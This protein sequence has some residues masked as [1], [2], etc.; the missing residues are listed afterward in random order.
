MKEPEYKVRPSSRADPKD[1]FRIFLSPSQLLLHNL[2]AGDVCHIVTLHQSSTRPAVVWPALE[3]IKDDVVQTSKALQVLYGLK[4]DSRISIRRGD[5]AI[6]DADEINICEVPQ[7][8]SE[9][10][11]PNVQKNERSHWAWILEYPLCNA[12]LLAP[13][14]TFDRVEAKGQ[15]R[16]FQIQSINSSTYPALYRARPSCRVHLNDGN[17]NSATANSFEDGKSLIVPSEGIG[18]LGEQLKQLNDVF[19]MYSLS[20]K[21]MSNLPLF[22]QKQG[23]ILLHGICGTGK[24][25]LLSNICKA[26]WRKVFHIDTIVYSQRSGEV[27]T[28]IRQTFSEARSCQPSVI[29]IDCL[30]SIAPT[31]NSTDLAVN[32]GRILS[33]ELDRLKGTQTLAVGATRS[34]TEIDHNLRRGGRLDSEIEIP[35]PD[36]KSRA[37]ILKTLCDLPKDKAHSTLDRVAARTYG[38]VGADLDRLLRQAVRISR[39]QDSASELTSRDSGC[40]PTEPIALLESME[41]AFN[42][43]MREIRPL[44]EHGIPVETPTTKWSDIGGQHEVKQLIGKA[45]WPFKVDSSLHPH[46]LPVTV[47]NDLAVSRRNEKDWAPSNEGAPI[48]WPSWVFENHDRKG[49]CH[50]VR[51]KLHSSQRRRNVEHVRRRD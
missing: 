11:L 15:K 46:V 30:E 37:E 29:I 36:S 39:A 49:S 44:A 8:E 40:R 17:G 41:D 42:S 33:R 47:A 27:E 13:G 12:E 51:S 25:K 18:G 31:Q 20:G 9:L 19:R 32:V 16:S 48:V 5:V 14:M 45:A 23:G 24:T 43:A 1:V 28:A 7:I 38:F 35:V 6:T 2:H 34:L 21:Q 50:R 10:T 4:L 22:F 26:G 3:K